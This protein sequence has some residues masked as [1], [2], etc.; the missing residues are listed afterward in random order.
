MW[1]EPNATVEEFGNGER[2]EA[3]IRNVYEMNGVSGYRLYDPDNPPYEVSDQGAGEDVEL[4][5][6]QTRQVY[7]QLG[8][9]I[10][11]WDASDVE[12]FMQAPGRGDYTVDHVRE[13]A[14]SC[15]AEGIPFC[16]T[17]KDWHRPAEEHNSK[18]S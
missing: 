8:K 12:D 13:I 2:R 1:T 14:Q 18:G 3:R 11:A 10:R 17:C 7:L 15:T 5:E 6:N 9:L 16:R 4:S